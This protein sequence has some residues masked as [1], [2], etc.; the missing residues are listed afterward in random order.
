MVTA[1]CA[2]WGCT[3]GPRPL[4]PPRGAPRPGAG[5]LEDARGTEGRG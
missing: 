1:L 2:V 4:L 3:H 5:S